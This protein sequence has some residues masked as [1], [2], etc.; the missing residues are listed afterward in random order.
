MFAKCVGWE[1]P[2]FHIFSSHDVQTIFSFGCYF[3]L[4]GLVWISVMFSVATLLLWIFSMIWLLWK[5]LKY[6]LNWKP[7]RLIFAIDV[8]FLC[9]Y[10]SVA[11]NI[12]CH[13]ETV[14]A[15][16]D[17]I[18]ECEWNTRLSTTRH[19]DVSWMHLIIKDRRVALLVPMTISVA[20]RQLPL[21]A[22][23]ASYL[24]S[25]WFISAEAAVQGS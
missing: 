11:D 7:R 4:Y 23:T 22:N 5:L 2:R 8:D 20:N 10:F 25:R 18:Y 14:V 19:G 3:G 13:L 21:A 6:T 24:L 17:Y 9:R 15:N 16:L 12:S 1:W